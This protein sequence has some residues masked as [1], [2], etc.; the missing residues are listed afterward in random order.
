MG[1]QDGDLSSKEGAIAVIEV[2][3]SAGKE[4]NGR[5]RS[6]SMPGYEQYAGQ[7]IPW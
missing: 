2:I 7:D 4:S 5:F 6:I 3:S 1:G